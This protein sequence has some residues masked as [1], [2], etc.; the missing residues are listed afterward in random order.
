[1]K[2]SPAAPFSV[3]S[4]LA[5]LAAGADHL[6]LR[7]RVNMSIG[8]KAAKSSH[9][10]RKSLTPKGNRAVVHGTRE[11]RVAGER[12]RVQHRV[13]RSSRAV[14]G[15]IRKSIELRGCGEVALSRNWLQSRGDRH[16]SD[17]GRADACT[18]LNPSATVERHE[19]GTAHQS[20][21]RTFRP[22]QG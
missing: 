13:V 7:V 20:S 2:T 9:S 1:M 22:P 12:V 17:H 5:A 10:A 4:E 21:R 3:I 15:T 6:Y 18:P 16:A 8:G 14:S 11:R 19:G